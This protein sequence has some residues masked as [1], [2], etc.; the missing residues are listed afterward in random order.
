MS[1]LIIFKDIEKKKIGNVYI[2]L[3][4]RSVELSK[5]FSLKTDD[6][7]KYL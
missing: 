7:T 1:N 2:L 3:C 6:I 5:A 4:L